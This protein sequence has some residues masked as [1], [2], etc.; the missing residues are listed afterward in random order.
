MILQVQ[1]FA[2][3]RE[4]IGD[5]CCSLEL[6]TGSTV[7]TIRSA[8]GSRYPQAKDLIARSAVAVNC[9][10]AANERVVDDVDEIAVIPPV[11]GGGR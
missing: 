8:L 10:F 6:S 1:L 9:E 11:S 5:E 7:A 2:R 4:L 3:V